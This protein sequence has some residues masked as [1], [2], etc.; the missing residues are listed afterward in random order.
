MLNSLQDEIDVLNQRLQ[1]SEFELRKAE[2]KLR[3]NQDFGA[4]GQPAEYLSAEQ[5]PIDV[6]CFE[7]I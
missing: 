4:Y 2:R 3:H 5:Q 1:I 7:A 6:S